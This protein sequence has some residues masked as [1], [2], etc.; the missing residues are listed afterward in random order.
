M[1]TLV[2]VV[3]T[4]SWLSISCP[5]M[6][7]T[8]WNDGRIHNIDYTITDDVRIDYQAPN[9]YTT[10][11]LITGGITPIPYALWGY[12]DSR[13]NV[14]GGTTRNGLTAR[15][16]CQVTVTGGLINGMFNAEHSSQI[17][18]SGGTVSG[19]NTRGHSFTHWS[20]GSINQM[21][22]EGYATLNIYGSNFAVDGKPV[23]FGQ[24][25]NTPIDRIR[26]PFAKLTGVLANGDTINSEFGVAEQGSINLV[27][28]P[29]PSSL[30][31]F[32]GGLAILGLFHKR[33]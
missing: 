3:M 9:K 17:T 28:V 15:D 2:L 21:E 16:R 6:A 22:I 4:V 1:K 8:Y 26:E 13:I 24:I 31:A 11:N 30:L 7:Y 32:C 5:V 19:L 12:G 29:E 27:P 20:G 25:T 33:R 18:I 23:G 10:V 14:S